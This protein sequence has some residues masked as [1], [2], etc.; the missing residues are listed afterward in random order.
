MTISPEFGSYVEVHAATGAQVVQ[1][2]LLDVGDLIR[3]AEPRLMVPSSL[4]GEIAGRGRESRM[5]IAAGLGERLKQAAA[6]RDAVRRCCS[7]PAAARWNANGSTADG[8]SRPP[9]PPSCRT[10]RRSI[11]CATP[12]SPTPCSGGAPVSLVAASFDTSVAMIEKTYSK[13]ITDHGDEQM[14]RAMFDIE[15]PITSNVVPLKAKA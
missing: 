2:A 7:M 14:R 5:P 10:A 4:K 15:P 1:I 11:A 3:G 9:R 6:G 8:S 13:N 12:R